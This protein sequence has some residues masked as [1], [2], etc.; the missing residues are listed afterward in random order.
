MSINEAV[1]AAAA[2][3]PP[4]PTRRCWRCLQHFA[5]N[6]EDVSTG[7]PEWWLCDPCQLTLIGDDDRNR[8]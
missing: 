7:H 4:P 8:A 2:A 3:E 5:C 6:A 1:E